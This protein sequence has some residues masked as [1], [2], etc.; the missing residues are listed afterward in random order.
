MSL[1]NDNGPWD[2]K[3]TLSCVFIIG[4]PIAIIIAVG[5]AIFSLLGI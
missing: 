3:G 4:V 1:H 2:P 5:F